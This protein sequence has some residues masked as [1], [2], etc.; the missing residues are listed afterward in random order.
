M[1]VKELFLH[2]SG[3]ISIP[4]LYKCL[5]EGSDDNIDETILCL[6]HFMRY[7]A[8]DHANK[9]ST[10]AWKWLFVNYTK[11]CIKCFHLIPYYGSW[12]TIIELFPR[13]F[14]LD[15]LDFVNCNYE[16]CIKNEQELEELRRQQVV[17]ETFVCAQ[18]AIDRQHLLDGNSEQVSSL[19][20]YLPN[21]NELQDRKYD[22][23]KQLCSHMNVSTTVYH[24][25]YVIPLRQVEPMFIGELYE[26]P[27]ITYRDVMTNP[28]SSYNMNRMKQLVKTS[29]MTPS[30]SRSIAVVDTNNLMNVQHS[31]VPYTPADIAKS[32]AML[33]G[34]LGRGVFN[35]R[36]I[37]FHTKP[38]ISRFTGKTIHDKWKDISKKIV[39]APKVNLTAVLRLLMNTANDAGQH[40]PAFVH[41]FTDTTYAEN[42]KQYPYTRS[43]LT[44]EYEAHSFTLPRLVFWELGS[45]DHSITNMNDGD[46]VMSG[47]TLFT[48]YMTIFRNATDAASVLKSAIGSDAM[49]PAR[50][51]IGHKKF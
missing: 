2:L 19:A 10:F 32:F 49:I 39:S 20:R 17:F 3:D 45:A 8:G 30:L 4:L 36:V 14:P 15:D 13:L 18:L 25:D 31:L 37:S 26:H 40:P 29:R 41:V 1:T 28:S 7:M 50:N 9:V 43:V 44:K 22:I 5:R 35:N 6:F 21:V 38:T 11:A 24:Q 27:V 33:F 48:S 46:L 42:V 34:H 51:C 47:F 16:A 12:Q 23:V